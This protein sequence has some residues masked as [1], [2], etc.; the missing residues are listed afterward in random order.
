M[1]IDFHKFVDEKLMAEG[2][3]IVLLN[4]EIVEQRIDDYLKFINS[5]RNEYKIVYGWKD[6][7]KEYIL[8]GLID[9]WK[10]SYSIINKKNELLLI[11]F[12]SLYGGNTVHMHFTYAARN[13]RN[14]DLGKLH[15]LKLCQTA[16]DN[17]VHLMEG[18]FPK[19]NSG[20]IILHLKMGW[21]IETMRNNFELLIQAVPEECLSKTYKLLK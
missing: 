2:L 18:F 4:K 11:N 14:M 19:Y 20:S 12:S 9:K 3:Q 15:M 7:S 5:V 17:N 8:N 1:A 21:K 6:E 13:S 16:I 10:Y